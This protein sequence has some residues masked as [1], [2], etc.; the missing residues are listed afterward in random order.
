VLYSQSF[1]LDVGY[2]WKNRDKLVSDEMRKAFEEG[3]KNLSKVL[4]GSVKFGELLEMW[5]PYHRLVVANH[6]VLP[7]KTQPAQ[8]IPAFGYAVTMNDPKFGTGIG[9]AL[10]S[11]GLLASLQFGVQLSEPEH[12]GVKIVAYRFPENK[13]YLNDTEGIRFSFEPCFAIVGDQFIAASTIELCKKLIT[14]VKRTATLPGTPAVW[15][16]KGY[17]AGGGS[18]LTALPDPLITEYMLRDGSGIE[19]ARK[20]VNDLAAWLKTLG[21]VRLEID[22]TGA[23]YRLDIV[24]TVGGV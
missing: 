15:R 24:W 22:E 17:A 6:D 2:F 3:E 8:Q 23:E 18:A 4:P 1:Y 20:Q 5:G 13:P 9:A 14:E 10:R 12:D 11:G 19:A 16:G 21:T 7:Y